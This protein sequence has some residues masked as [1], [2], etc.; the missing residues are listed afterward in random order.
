MLD[1]FFPS[2]YRSAATVIPIIAVSILFSGVY[3]ILPIGVALQRKTWI[4]TITITCAALLNVGL[5][6]ILIPYYGSMGAAV[7]TLIA[8]IVLAMIAYVVNQRLYPVPFEI[9]LFSIA[10]LAGIAIYTGS[11][12]LARARGMYVGWG[13]RIGGL[14]F[15]GVCLLLLGKLAARK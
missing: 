10:L 11:D 9:G 6:I 2:A 14:I 3:V 5:N 8:Y 4:T 1:M 13:I 15:Y 12:F 7:A